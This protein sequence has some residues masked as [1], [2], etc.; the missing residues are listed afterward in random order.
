MLRQLIND[1]LRG[2]LSEYIYFDDSSYSFTG[3]PGLQ[4]LRFALASVDV[5]SGLRARSAPPAQPARDSAHR[6]AVAR[7]CRRAGGVMSCQVLMENV[8]V[9]ESAFSKLGLPIL[10]KSGAVGKLELSI[11]YGNFYTKPVSAGWWR[12]HR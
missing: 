2:V 8:R 6:A 1:R 9:K 4:A 11:P 3:A 10:V 7:L 5:H 12:M